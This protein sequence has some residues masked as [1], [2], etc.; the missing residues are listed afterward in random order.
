[1]VRC[2]AASDGDGDDGAFSAQPID[3]TARG[4]IGV[5]TDVTVGEHD[6]FDR[7]VFEFAAEFEGLTLAPGVPG[8]SIEYVDAEQECGSGFDVVTEGSAMLR[9]N[10]PQAYVYNPN[11]GEGT[12]DS[13]EMTADHQVI[14][15]VEETCGFEGQ[16]TWIIGTTGEQPFRVFELSSPTRLVIDI[17]T[18]P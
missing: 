18:A 8:Y 15:E 10:F 4:G 6:G 17:A 11:T 2:R 14:L 9:V 16:A 5:F 12:L 7:I 3:E 13:L 1:S